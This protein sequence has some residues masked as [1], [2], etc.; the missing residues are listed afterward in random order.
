MIG[1]HTYKLGYQLKM[2]A[3]SYLSLRKTKN[4][5]PSVWVSAAESKAEPLGHP[6]GTTKRL[7]RVGSPRYLLCHTLP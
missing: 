1:A 7:L 4:G 3:A 6:G 5:A 2:S